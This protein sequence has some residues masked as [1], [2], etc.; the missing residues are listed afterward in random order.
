MILK[1][2][3]TYVMG[4]QVF[5]IGGK[6]VYRPHRYLFLL[7]LPKV[8][9]KNKKSKSPH[10]FFKKKKILYIIY[11]FFFFSTLN[12]G[13]KIYKLSQNS[14]ENRFSHIRPEK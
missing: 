1:F 7:D 4:R 6:K 14:K 3:F 13:G 8:F 11:E 9:N 5:E 10:F 2:E 12:Y